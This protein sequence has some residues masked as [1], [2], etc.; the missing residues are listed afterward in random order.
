M[1]LWGIGE[2]SEQIIVIIYGRGGHQEQMSRLL[3]KDLI[4]V[5]DQ[6]KLIG[7]TDSKSPINQ[8][9]NRNYQFKEFRDKFSVWRTY[10]NF[11]INS[12]QLVLVTLYLL[13]RYNVKGVI[14]T[15]PGV[16]IIPC[17]L[18]SLLRKKVVV[19]ESWSKFTQPSKTAKL[20]YR[21]AGLFI[22]QNKAMLECFPKAKFWGRL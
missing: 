14:T 6:V 11:P 1:D 10:L 4:K 20:L 21:F 5:Q 12:I 18:L 16:A 22:V 13:T 2:M 15:G 17:I 3:K 8:G 9:V 7:M 19:F